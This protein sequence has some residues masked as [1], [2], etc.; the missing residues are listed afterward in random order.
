[1]TDTLDLHMPG[2]ISEMLPDYGCFV[3]AWSSYAVAW[4]VVAHMF[5]IVPRADLHTL[6]VD[7]QLPPEWGEAR[8]SNV[9][10]GSARFDFLWDGE[11]MHV[12]CDDE[13]WSILS[14]T[15]PLQVERIRVPVSAAANGSPIL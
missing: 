11:T 12:D 15:V 13:A 10:I 14:S 2:A 3:Q 5:G 8:L 7:P 1:M 6:A 9:R 4:P